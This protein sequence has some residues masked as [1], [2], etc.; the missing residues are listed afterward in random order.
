M[1]EIITGYIEHIIGY[2]VKG[3]AGLEVPRDQ[4]AQLTPEGL[5]LITPEGRFD[6]RGLM[7][8]RATP[9]EEGIFEFVTQRDKRNK[10]DKP[11]GLSV[12]AL[13]QP[14]F[15]GPDLYL[16]WKGQDPIGVPVNITGQEIP[17]RIWDDVCMAIDQ[18][19]PLAKWVSDHLQLPTRLVRAAG[20]FDRMARQNYMA[21]ASHVRFQDGYP[22]HWFPEESV[23][24]LNDLIHQRNS[25]ITVP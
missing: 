17:V 23:N 11:Q 10:T 20:S 7:I 9:N 4:Y 25:E 14:Q 1:S 12:L 19:G 18:G 5:T 13:I 22:I 16:T 21:N 6:D 3:G 15:V 2:P 8:V 24:E